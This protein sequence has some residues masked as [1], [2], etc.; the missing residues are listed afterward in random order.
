M[1]MTTQLSAERTA[2]EQE[3]IRLERLFWSS[4]PEVY[5]QNADEECLIAFP[6][7]AQV[8]GRDE[9]AKM[10]EEGRWHDLSIDKKGLL[11]PSENIA[12]LTYE[13]KAKRKDGQPYQALVSSAYI[14]RDDGW[15]LAFHQQTPVEKPDY[16]FAK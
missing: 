12:I 8:V 4:K 9:M 16:P 6:G 5:L 13:A 2:T 3:L 15:K 1:A 10:A 7:M 14:K 11:E